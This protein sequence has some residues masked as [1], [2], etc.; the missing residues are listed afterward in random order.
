M[1]GKQQAYIKEID[2]ALCSA[3]WDAISELVRRYRKQN[4]SDA[5]F[6]D[7]VLLETHICQAT[8]RLMKELGFSYESYLKDSPTNIS[9]TP[10]LSEE[11]IKSTVEKL[12]ELCEKYTKKNKVHATIVLARAYFSIGAWQEALKVLAMIEIPEKLDTLEYSLILI[13]QA[14]TIRGVSSEMLGDY[15]QALDAYEQAVILFKKHNLAEKPDQLIAWAEESMYRAPLLKL[16]LGDT[17]GA[18]E[19]LRAYHIEAQKWPS[20]F[21]IHKRAVIYRHFAKSVSSFLQDNKS[22]RVSRED[23]SSSSLEIRER[24]YQELTDV[25]I[26][27]E[28]TL[29]TVTKF[30]KSGDV[31]DLII[32]LVEHEMENLNML[33]NNDLK[34]LRRVVELL[35]RATEKTFNS[36]CI[37]RHLVKCLIVLGEF[38]EAEHAI[39]S[40][41]ELVGMSNGEENKPGDH[42][43]K[44]EDL[45][46][47]DLITSILLVGA[48]ISAKEF[49]NGEKCV[50]YSKKAIEISKCYDCKGEAEAW[51]YLG[52]GYSLLASNGFDPEARSSYHSKSVEALDK[53]I[54][55]EPNIWQTHY[56]LAIQY[57]EIRDIPQAILSVR[58][59]L[60]LLPTHVPSWHLLVLLFSCSNQGGV[61]EGLKWSEIAIKELENGE[62]SAEFFSLRLTH[63][64]LLD[65]VHGPVYALES[66]R[67]LFVLFSKISSLNTSPLAAFNNFSTK[68]G[69]IRSRLSING[70]GRSVSFDE[71]GET[72]L[73]KIMNAK[74]GAPKRSQSYGERLISDIQSSSS[75]FSSANGHFTS[76]SATIQE[77]AK[78]KYTMKLLVN[79]WLISASAFRRAGKY[80]D[81]IKAIEEADKISYDDPDVWYQL[82]Q[83]L[84]AQQK[85]EEATS[86][87]HRA[88]ALDPHHNLSKVLLAGIYFKNHIELAEGLLESVTKGVGWDCAEAWLLLSKLY[89][90]MEFFERSKSCLIYAMELEASCPIRPFRVLPRCV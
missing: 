12:K 8:S 3:N 82:A 4:P 45:E 40:Y 34:E 29:F 76:K 37:L 54:K 25:C 72:S 84:L 2:N 15:N 55:L 51:R 64:Q 50:R 81:A 7:L 60:T 52:V 13:V 83:L 73:D 80:E 44:G 75:T 78:H 56:Q 1:S 27:W 46:P 35:H 42:K 90:Q 49:Q 68:H 69:S 88:L 71:N 30:P 89:Q 36:P 70:V 61:Q 77:T 85:Q 20:L 62:N 28:K 17:E 18:L 43:R 41:L 38:N 87:L 23:M 58:Q 6:A 79:L 66:R 32:E 63:A 21:R 24:M 16:R 48:R 14:H 65:N 10:R 47:A 11:R 22:L 74:S 39:D 33:G 59:A 19:S 57:A 53:S 86:S 5:A 9:I 67:E 26:Q 31:N